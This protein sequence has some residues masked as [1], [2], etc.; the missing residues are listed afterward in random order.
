MSSECRDQLRRDPGFALFTA[1]DCLPA[2][3]DPIP[4]LT[5][6]C[7]RN[8]AIFEPFFFFCPPL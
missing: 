8:E 1:S 7:F 5:G 3:G 4:A 2:Q 6:L